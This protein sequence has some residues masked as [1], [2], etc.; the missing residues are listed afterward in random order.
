MERKGQGARAHAAEF[1]VEL[2]NT[3]RVESRVLLG[4]VSVHALLVKV[5]SRHDVDANCVQPQGHAV[6]SCVE[7]VLRDLCVRVTDGREEFAK[8]AARTCGTIS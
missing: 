5:G 7:R 1:G 6:W 8:R 3:S 4:A 2:V